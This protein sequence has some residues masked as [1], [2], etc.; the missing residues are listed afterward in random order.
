MTVP[1]LCNT[2]IGNTPGHQVSSLSLAVNG[3]SRV[4]TLELNQSAVAVFQWWSVIQLVT[5]SAVLVVKQKV[6]FG[7]AWLTL[8]YATPHMV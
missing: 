8:K 6:D 4:D 2:K 5:K 1:I 7:G 3:N